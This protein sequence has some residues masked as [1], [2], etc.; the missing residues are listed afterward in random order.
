[1]MFN[2]QIRNEN[3]IILSGRFDASQEE[4]A[5][6]VFNTINKSCIVNFEALDYISSSGLGVLLATQ[7][8]LSETGNHLKLVNMNDHIRDVFRYARFDMI[9]EIE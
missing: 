3:E 4:K 2:I 6:K 8:R 5:K 7:K 1:M 9:F